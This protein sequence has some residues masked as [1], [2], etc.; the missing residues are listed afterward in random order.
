MKTQSQIEI[1]GL[2]KDFL[3][4][5][6]T[7]SRNL[8]IDYYLPIVKYTAERLR[9]RFPNSVEIE[10]IQGAGVFGLIDAINKFDLD[11]GVL[12]ETYC[13][14]RIR[15]AILDDIRNKDW[16]PRL[17]RK[18]AQQ[19]ANTVQKLETIFGHLPSDQELAEEMD[20][21]IDAF[22]RFQRNA[23]AAVLLS[24]HSNMSE[25]DEA[26]EF[27]EIN[28]IANSKSQD[29]SMEVQK[30]DTRDYITKGFSREEKL[31]VTLYY[32]EEMTM[33]EIGEVL[34]IS[35]SRVCQ[36]HSSLISLLQARVNRQAECIADI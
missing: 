8:L 6:D 31:V 30:Q 16:V 34:G 33:R 36:I 5:R 11:R 20:L 18:Q 28:V 21:E 9:P 15:G 3:A 17:V 1:S 2:W 19:L 13:V 32:Y 24:L 4:K 26:E 25:W 7:H 10:D 23:N 29:P 27:Q 14:Q 12:F 35:E 22:Y